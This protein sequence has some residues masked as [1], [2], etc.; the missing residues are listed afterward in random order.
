MRVMIE[1][2]AGMT[3]EQLV[4]AF[5]G[6]KSLE[7][8]KGLTEIVDERI[9]TLTD[10]ALEEKI[11]ERTLNRRLGGIEELLRLKFRVEEKI[12]EADESVKSAMNAD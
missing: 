3:E 12:E 8:Y 7:F 11:A 9:T 4:M 1:H 2:R 10:D 6:G 5:A